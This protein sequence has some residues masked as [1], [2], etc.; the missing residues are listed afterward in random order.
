MAKY[1]FSEDG[2]TLTIFDCYKYPKETY[3]KELN[4]IKA[5]HGDKKIFERTDLSL[6]REW[7]VH[8]A[9]YDL[10]Y[11]RE[12]TKDADLDNPCDKPEWVYM[13]LGWIVWPF[14]P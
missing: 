11:R 2:S 8:A 9:L 5:I 13:F 12:R 1:K 10:H 3:Q 14:L 4:Q 6:K 7:A